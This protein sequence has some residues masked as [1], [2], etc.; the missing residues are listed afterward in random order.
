MKPAELD[1]IGRTLFG[2]IYARDLAEAL[3]VTDRTI[4]RYVAGE[5]EI[6]LDMKVRLERL[7]RDRLREI[8]TV[9]ARAAKIH[10]ARPA[11]HQQSAQGQPALQNQ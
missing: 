11:P 10:G 3:G 9:L 4:R 8:T 6:P 7:A 1:Q 5:R 2:S